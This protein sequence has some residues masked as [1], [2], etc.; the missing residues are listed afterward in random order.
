MSS[1]A[2]SPHLRRL[3]W[4]GLLVSLAGVILLAVV[5]RFE[6]DGRRLPN[7]GTLPGFL[8][9]NRDGRE[10]SSASLEGKPWVA[11]FI[12]TRCPGP[13]PKMTAK[14]A[15]LGEQLPPGFTRVSF[16]VD[17]EHDTPA[18][19]TAYAERYQAPPS[20]LFLTGGREAIYELANLGFKLLAA[21]AEDAASPEGPI[22]HSTRF[23]LVDGEG[24]IRGYYDAFDPVEENRL[25]ADA[26]ALAR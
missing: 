25:V 6:D 16:S 5:R 15:K 8:L 18:V 10:V 12:F 23:V 14:M 22:L 19:L 17:P 20:W 11:S 1:P 26:A 3:L 21:P 24:R 9:T 2:R 4:L 7:Y 13:C